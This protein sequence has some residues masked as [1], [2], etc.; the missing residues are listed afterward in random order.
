MVEREG[1]SSQYKTLEPG[2]Y[3]PLTGKAHTT[4]KA[5][6]PSVVA[7]TA[8]AIALRLSRVAP[9]AVEGSA[10]IVESLQKGPDTLAGAGYLFAC[11]QASV[12]AAEDRQMTEAQKR[13]VLVAPRSQSIDR[14]PQ[15]NSPCM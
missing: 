11:S 3:W 13:K 6:S 14:Q 9:S 15:Q 1:G 2:P 7:L 4:C 10:G 8:V 5:W 12:F